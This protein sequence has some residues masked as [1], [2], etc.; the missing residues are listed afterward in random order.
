MPQ[1]S[2]EPAGIQGKNRDWAGIGQGFVWD[3]AGE[4]TKRPRVDAEKQEEKLDNCITKPIYWLDVRLVS[5]AE[6]SREMRA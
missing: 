5:A 3:E 1:L 4:Y 6:S 2:L